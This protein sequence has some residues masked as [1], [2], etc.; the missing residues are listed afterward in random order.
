MTGDEPARL[1]HGRPP[2]SVRPGDHVPVE[3][4]FDPF[5]G[6]RRDDPPADEGDD[7]LVSTRRG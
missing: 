2:R 4:E 3:D 5:A 7:G 6:S 1:A